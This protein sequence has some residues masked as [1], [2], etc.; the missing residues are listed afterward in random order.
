LS[1]STAAIRA[2]S[3]VGLIAKARAA[4]GAIRTVDEI[5]SKNAFAVFQSTLADVIGRSA[6][7]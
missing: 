7:A 4:L 6:A 2:T 1:E 5:Q 3:Q